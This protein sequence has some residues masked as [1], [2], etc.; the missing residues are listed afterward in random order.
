MQPEKEKNKVN[1]PLKIIFTAIN[2]FVIAILALIA[3][4]NIYNLISRNF[5]D[6]SLPKF[7][8]YTNAV[9]IS[10]S[11]SGEIEVNDMVIVRETET[12]KAGDIIMFK[13]ESGSFVTHRI[14]RIEP[15]GEGAFLYYTKGDANNAEDK[16][17]I[18]RS[19]IEG[20]VVA[21]IPQIGAFIE[22]MQTPLGL[23]ILAAA[24]F[25][26][27]ELPIFIEKLISRKNPSYYKS[28]H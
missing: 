5:F 25:L 17:P 1:K 2:V 26:I 3:F 18:T 28:K 11:M 24:A 7:L 6:N 27:I 22:F 10:G 19:Q 4:F 9:V 12:Y 8:G 14:T 16:D 20:K 15:D 23:I 13:Q 21:V